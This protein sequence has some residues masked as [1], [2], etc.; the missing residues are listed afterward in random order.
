[1]NGRTVY[2][3]ERARSIPKKGLQM[4]ILDAISTVFE[5]IGVVLTTLI[6]AIVFLLVFSAV[7]LR[8]INLNFALYEELSRW[9]LVGMTF[10]GASVALKRKLHVGINMLVQAFPLVIAK[11]CIVVAFLVVMA[12]LVISGWFSLRAA[13]GTAGMTGDIVPVSMMYVKF[14]LPLGMFMM[15]VHLLDGFFKIFKSDSIDPVLIGS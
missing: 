4:K 6:L 1:M 13:L 7:I 12:T 11:V 15:F 8:A 9:C 14:T 5:K 2:Q 10:L 3:P